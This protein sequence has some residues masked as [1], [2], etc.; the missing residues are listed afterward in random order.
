MELTFDQLIKLLLGV[1]VIAAIIFGLYNFGSNVN[2]FFKSDEGQSE[3]DVP[4]NIIEVEKPAEQKASLGAIGGGIGGGVAG[5]AAG[6]MF[7]GPIGCVLGGAAGVLGGAVF[8][9]IIGKGVSW[10]WDKFR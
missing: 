8:G 10:M 9:D 3:K 1:I 5:C 6:A 7:G 4:D 2:E